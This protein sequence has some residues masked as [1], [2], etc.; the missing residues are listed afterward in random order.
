MLIAGFPSGSLQAN[1]YLIGADD[2]TEIVVIDPGEN[3]AAT[4]ERALPDLDRKVAGVLLTH[5][6]LDHCAD[7]AQ[8]ADAHQV[9]VYCHVDDWPMLIE[10]MRGLLDEFAP[11]AASITGPELKLPKPQQLLDYP[12]ELFLAG[13]EFKVHHAPGHSPG[14][15]VLMIDADQPVALTGDVIF[16]G[17]IGRVD[18][19]GGDQFQMTSSLTQ[20]ARTISPQTALLPGHGPA[21]T[22]AEEL[23]SNRYLQQ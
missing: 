12:T 20:L 23:A 13:V 19:P 10:P 9:P 21:S 8:I 1:C 11:Y 3:A 14:S 4:I 5:G 6:H 18:L 17:S 22:M 15:V 7:A 2:S 16:A